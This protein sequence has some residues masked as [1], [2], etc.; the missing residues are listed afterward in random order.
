MP[1]RALTVLSVSRM[2]PPTRGQT[3]YFDKGYP[4]LA[5]RV[6]YGGSMSWALFYR[7]HGGKLRRMTLGRYPAMSLADARAAWQ[8]AR[9]SVAK[10]ENPA[11]RKPVTADTFAAAA[12]DWL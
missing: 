11:R 9:R 1:T 3:D 8:D 10:G 7:L 2:K 12:A 6:S 5:L 4:G